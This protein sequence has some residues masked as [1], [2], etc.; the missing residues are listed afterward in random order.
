MKVQRNTSWMFYSKLC[1][2]LG[3]I[4]GDLQKSCF[5]ISGK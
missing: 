2:L 1:E 3:D 4:L 5:L